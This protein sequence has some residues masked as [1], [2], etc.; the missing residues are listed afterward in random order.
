[1]KLVLYDDY[2]PG[3]LKGDAV[4]DISDVTRDVAGRDGQETMTGIIGNFESLRPVLERALS[5]GPEVPLSS[6]RLRAPLPKPGKIVCMGVSFREFT[7]QPGLPLLVFLKSPD[8]VLDPEGTVILP[9]IDFPIC[10]HE[11]EMTVVMGKTAKNVSEAEAMDYVFGYTLG[12]DVSCRGPWG[13]NVFTG[14][15]FDTFCPMGP[16]ITTKDEVPNPHQLQVRFWVDGQPR[17]DY[18]M[19]DIARPI[20]RLVAYSSSLMTLHPGEPIMLGTNHQGIGPLQD[21]ETAEME[22]EGL[23]RLRFK[24]SDPKKRSWPKEIDKRMAELVKGAVMRGKLE[25]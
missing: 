15:S 23:G 21:G 5:S 17:H 20:Q 3:L 7:D 1:M 22:I 24:V 8:A 6:V 19:S 12:V 2:R 4:V 18:N 10:H 14:K 13:G 11:A 9:D 16:C 25:I